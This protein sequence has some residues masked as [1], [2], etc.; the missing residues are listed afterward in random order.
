MIFSKR[1]I[2]IIFF[3]AINQSANGAPVKGLFSW[4]AYKGMLCANN[5]LS[6]WFEFFFERE[7]AAH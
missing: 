6:I 5:S 1:K 7:Y 3:Y 2:L 4:F